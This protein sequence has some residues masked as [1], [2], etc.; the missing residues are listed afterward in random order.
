MSTLKRIFVVFLAFAFAEVITLSFKGNDILDRSIVLGLG[1]DKDGDSLLVTAEILSPGNGSEQVGIY[2]KIVTARGKTVAEAI[3]VITEETGK[4]TSLG[5]C[6]LV[7]FGEEFFTK[8]DF[9]DT[10]DYLSS[11]NSFK[12]SSSIC[13]CLG[14]AQDLFNK[15]EALS[16]SISLALVRMLRE[17]AHNVAIPSNVLLQFVRSQQELL[18]TGYL[19]LVSYVQ[20]DNVDVQNPDKPQGFFLYDSVAVFRQNKFVTVVDSGIT[21]GF[22]LLAKNVVGSTFISQYDNQNMTVVVNSKKVDVSLN[23]QD[24]GVT[25]KVK[26]SVSCARAD[27]VETGGVFSSKQR[28]Q[29]PQQVMDDVTRQAE[30]QIQQFLSFQQR[31]N[32]DV[33]NL[34]EAY[35]QKYGSTPWVCS[36]PM[37]DIPISLEVTVK[38]R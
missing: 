10:I 12:E 34:H 7:V 24:N 31:H 13:C 1:V 16:R 15:T 5:Q 17:Q 29:I 20:S 30:E 8:Q 2:S 23:K 18:C 37:T 27:S 28:Q 36:L 35:R 11:S 33:I 6:V 26:L 22:A 14:S 25:V 3:R 4:E 32:F 9:A 38:D 19:N 21:Q